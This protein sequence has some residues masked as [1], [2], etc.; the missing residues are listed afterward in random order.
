MKWNYRVVKKD[1]YLGIHGVYYDENGNITGI[2]QDPNAPLG[3]ELDELRTTLVHPNRSFYSGL[4][5]LSMPDYE[6]S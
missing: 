3:E 1:G 4:K 6:V 5:P 2:D